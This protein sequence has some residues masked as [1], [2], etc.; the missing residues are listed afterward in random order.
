[1]SFRKSS[2]SRNG[3]NSDVL[4]NPNARRKCTPAPSSVG[5][6]LLSRLIGLMDMSCLH[7]LLTG[8]LYPNR[9]SKDGM[10]FSMPCMLP[11]AGASMSIPV[12]STYCFAYPFF[13][14]CSKAICRKSGIAESGHRLRIRKLVY[15]VSCRWHVE[16][17]HQRGE[18]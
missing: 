5:L 11:T 12:D 13:C 17:T 1:M 3:S 9:N 4:P 16:C 10:L 2:R 6:D 7:C 14:V 15:V 8:N 18:L